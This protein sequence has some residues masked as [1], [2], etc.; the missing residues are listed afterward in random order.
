MGK[1]GRLEEGRR[2]ELIAVED[3][4]KVLKGLSMFHY[5]LSS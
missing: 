2:E 3:L 5:L 1:N 4:R